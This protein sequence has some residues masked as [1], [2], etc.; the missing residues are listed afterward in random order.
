MCNAHP[1]STSL[2]SCLCVFPLSP[3]SSKR[4]QASNGISLCL[5]RS[6]FAPTTVY[7]SGVPYEKKGRE[8]RRRCTMQ[9]P[10]FTIFRRSRGLLFSP[11]STSPV[12]QWRRHVGTP[13]RRFATEH[14]DGTSAPKSYALSAQDF[15]SITPLL[16]LRQ[17]LQQHTELD[18]I[19]VGAAFPPGEKRIVISRTKFCHFC[20]AAHVEDPQAALADL[21]AAGV[22]VVLDGGDM[23][24]LRPVLY[25]DTLETIRN[26]EKPSSS[27]NG[28]SEAKSKLSGAASSFMLEEAERRVAQLT[29]R[30]KAMR[31]QL[32]PAIARAARWRRTVWGSALLYAGAQLAIISRLTYFDL[33]WDIMEP[34]SYII[35]ATHALFFFM[36]YLRFHEEH[37]YSAFDRRFL[38]RKVR[39]YAPK[40]FD[41]AAYAAVCEQLV[42]ERALRDSILKWSERH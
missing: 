31:N 7:N 1:I 14:A 41:W 39:H 15:A 20:A 29:E 23:V 35:T 9:Y 21:E 3:I 12:S 17:M 27:G 16:L 2:T 5:L 11:Q 40:D 6:C 30:E 28:T 18:G 19:D 38:P 13:G 37:S 24:H 8:A 42:E 36:Y 10:R 33:D 34:V 26:V 25:L 32:Q 4:R 22:V